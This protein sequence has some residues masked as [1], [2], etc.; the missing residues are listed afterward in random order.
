[1]SA[2]WLARY[3]SS[4]SASSRRPVAWSAR[5]WLRRSS[6]V[7]ALS[8]VPWASYQLLKGRYRERSADELEAGEAVSP[9]LR[10]SALTAST[11]SPDD[12]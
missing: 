10:K 5:A 1:M 11:T 4:S 2:S 3:S 9:W 6:T 12:R 7:A 8:V